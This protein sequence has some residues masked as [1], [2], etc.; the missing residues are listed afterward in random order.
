VL[1]HLSAG[2]DQAHRVLMGLKMALTMKDSGKSVLVYCDIDA[3]KWLVREAPVIKHKGFKTSADFLLDLVAK[4]VAIRA[5]PSCLAAAGK[6]PEDLIPGVKT[7]NA[8]EFFSFAE[9][10]I[11]TLDY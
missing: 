8:D 7:A 2:P 6:S 11:I 4:K 3:V 10:R 9:G 1:I 5:C